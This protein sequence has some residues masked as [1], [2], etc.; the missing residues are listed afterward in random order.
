MLLTQ[1]KGGMLRYR[2]SA[3]PDMNFDFNMLCEVGAPYRQQFL[4]EILHKGL[5]VEYGRSIDCAPW[6]ADFV[7]NR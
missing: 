7:V 2:Y 1:L 3:G 6:C 5:R 4:D